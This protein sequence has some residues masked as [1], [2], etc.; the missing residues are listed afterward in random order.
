MQN[1]GIDISNDKF[2]HFFD[3]TQELLF[4]CENKILILNE[5]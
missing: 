2:E 4:V 1:S 5:L 3:L